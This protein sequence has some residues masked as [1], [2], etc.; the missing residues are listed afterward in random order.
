MKW[1]T[2]LV[3]NS[4]ARTIGG[5]AEARYPEREIDFVDNSPEFRKVYPYLVIGVFGK[6]WDDLKTLTDE[7]VTTAE[8]KTKDGRKII[9]SNI[10]DFF[11]DFEKHYGSTLP[12][13]QGGFGNEWDLYTASVTE[14]SARVRRSVEKLRAAEAMASLVSLRRPNFLIGRS[15]A[16]DE[17][18]MNLGLFWEHNWTADGTAVRREQ[19]AEWGRR[20]AENV[21]RYVDT[22]YDDSAHALAGMLQR[23][24]QNRRFYVFNPLGWTRT[25]AA[26]IPLD[27]S[28]PVHVVD[29]TS[30]S[31]V[32]SQ[33]VEL[34]AS[35]FRGTARFLRVLATDL[36]AI[37]YK[38][39]EVRDGK[40][41]QFSPAAVVTGNV[42]ESEKYR[43]QL[44][45]EVPS[46]VCST[47]HKA[48]ASSWAVSK[49]AARSST[50]W[51]ST[52][53]SLRSKT[54]DRCR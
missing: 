54:Q 34:P 31:E 45:T 21:E 26:D 42:V 20:V 2:M 6:G 23:S 19:R 15:A 9:V 52:P 17:A 10:N 16:R 51:D 49:M 24:G 41:Q 27:G 5:Y 25:D 30:G 1:N 37:G 11:I 28:A 22:L 53:A 36:P 39:F 18:W 32:P 46:G 43:I 7:F 48:T 13:Y 44:E 29:L 38:V 40:G 33:V 4:G 35:D 8:K 3:G 47:R 14:L 12:E 50:I